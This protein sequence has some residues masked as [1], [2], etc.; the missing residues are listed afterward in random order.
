MITI[1]FSFGHDPVIRVIIEDDDPQE[2]VKQ[3]Q[4]FI[5]AW[6]TREDDVFS[7]PEI[8]EKN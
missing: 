2:A 6:A 7:L 1:D 8:S 4:E 3:F 5:K